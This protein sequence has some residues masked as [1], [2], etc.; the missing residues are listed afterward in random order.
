MGDIVDRSYDSD[1]LRQR[2]EDA[3]AIAQAMSLPAAK[4]EM[5]QIAKLYDRLA[6]HSERT[7]ERK[8]SR[9]RA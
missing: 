3:R 7:T 4:R 2:A 1:H 9:S 5:L 6:N 8:A